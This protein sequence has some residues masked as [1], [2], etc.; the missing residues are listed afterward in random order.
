[1]LGN[2]PHISPVLH[3]YAR[4]AVCSSYTFAL[5]KGAQYRAEIIDR[6]EMTITPV[7]GTFEGKFTMKL[8]GKPCLA[9]RFRKV[10]AQ[11]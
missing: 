4:P 8:P 2:P 6:S 10:R 5:A 7:G 9:V 1:V 3:K 11:E